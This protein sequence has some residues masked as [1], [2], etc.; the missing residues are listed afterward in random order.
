[1]AS[2]TVYW[3]GRF[4][5]AGITLNLRSVRPVVDQLPDLLDAQLT[6]GEVVDTA[7]HFVNINSVVAIP[8]ILL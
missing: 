5:H 2:H 8:I 7:A 1:M 3:S 6:A 4:Q